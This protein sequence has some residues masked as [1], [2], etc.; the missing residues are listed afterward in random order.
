MAVRTSRRYPAPSDQTGWERVSLWTLRI[1][2]LLV[3]LMVFFPPFN[4]G[5][6]STQ[7]SGNLTLLTSATSYST[8]TTKL[9][10]YMI[11]GNQRFA[12]RA[13][14]IRQSMA[15]CAMIL[16][17]AAAAGVGACI[18]LGNRKMRRTGVWFPLG[19]GAL[20]LGGLAVN[21]A[22][23]RNIRAFVES[24]D[25]AYVQDHLKNLSLQWP[26]FAHAA[27]TAGGILILAASAAALFFAYRRKCAEAKAEME[28]KYKL[29]IM[30]LPV[31]AL[32]FVFAYLPIYGWR[33]AFY[34]AKAGDELTKEIFVGFDN[35][36]MLIND[37]GFSAKILQVLRNTLV[38]SGLGIATSWL[39]IAFAIL[40]AEVRNTRF[41]RTVQ[42]LTTIPNFLSWV[43]VYAVALSI[44]A[45]DGLI[46]NLNSIFSPMGFV[47]TDYLA[48]AD[49]TWIKMLLWG[50]WKG[51]GWSA[52]I[53]VAGIAGI[54][55]QLYEAAK[56]DGAN[57][58]RCIWHIT[59][60]G[61]IPTYMVMLLMSVAGILSNGME[62]Y[63]VFSNPYNG[64]YIQV[65]DLY[66]Y[67][68]G[69]GNNQLSVSTVIGIL[70]SLI[71]VVLLFGANGI[72]K[73]VRGE[74]I[75]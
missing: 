16:A 67:N 3:L 35:F 44:F 43:L 7:I 39:P 45:A 9:S 60:P 12:L 32:S 62:Q 1:I 64:D 53:Y 61:L 2:I 47:R 71:A 24:M 42:T 31:L 8:V 73:A 19:G 49:A 36:T 41:Q 37:P 15:G 29:F 28:E 17:G 27:W 26:V 50:T 65:L 63:L 38:M 20:I 58:F 74:S 4:P 57:R 48:S 55:Q 59:V 11:E 22:A 72:S 70:K 13:A 34:D 25:A 46:N 40:L 69:I 14:D 75:I 30:F 6:I 23:Y 54:D 33:Y 52:I 18:S 5:R 10:A 21:S 66:V 51:L 68:L 56:V